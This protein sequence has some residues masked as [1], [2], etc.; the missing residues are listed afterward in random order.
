[1]QEVAFW[2]NLENALKKI[3]Q[4]CESDGVRLT[5]DVLNHAK[6]F[7]ATASFSANA[8][9]KERI[10]T[11][12]NYNLFMRDLP[13][14]DLISATDIDSIYRALSQILG[15]MKKVRNSNYPANRVNAF[16]YALSS[17]SVKQ[18]LK[19]LQAQRLLAIPINEFD[20]IIRKT[21]EAISKLEPEYEKILNFAR[22]KKKRDEFSAKPVKMRMQLP[23]KNLEMRLDSIQK[24]RSQHEQLN[25]VIQR[26]VR[27]TEIGAAND[28]IDPL[29]EI[30]IA[31]DGV[32]EVDCLDLSVEGD[33]VWTQANR[34]YN[35]RINRVE[36][37]LATQFREQL[38]ST[39]S[40]EEM[41]KIFSRYNLLFY[42]KHIK[43]AIREY[44]TK[45]IERVKEDIINLENIFQDPEQQ[46]RAI[47]YMIRQDMP[48][49][50]SRIIW[51][52]QILKQLDFCMK[53][54]ADVL[55]EDWSNH[56]DGMHF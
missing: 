12:N 23:H 26:V 52:Q 36:N 6:R 53:R 47:V 38:A 4:Q 45:L 42:R 54:V 28:G 21:M 50:A 9:L 22:D 17:D 34:F 10:Q 24:F 27:V 3:E 44:Q 49:V 51:N 39:H 30:A 35:E 5:L 56:K 18:F 1:M 29:K 41:F 32:K 25:S 13:L 20:Q 11:A 33:Q 15:G 46:R 16:I 8:G 31:Y 48:E 37:H 40:A 14:N 43:S 55:G 19:V 7:H 2:L